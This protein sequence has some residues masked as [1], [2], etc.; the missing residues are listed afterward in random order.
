MGVTCW[1]YIFEIK[2]DLII[3]HVDA[4]C[5]HDALISHDNN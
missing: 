1:F 5:F 3:F 4:V 2:F